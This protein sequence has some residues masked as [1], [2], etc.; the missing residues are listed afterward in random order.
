M[1]SDIVRP[2]D[3]LIKNHTKFHKIFT[4]SDDLVALDPKKY[5]KNNYSFCFPEKINIGLEGRDKLCT[6]IAGNKMIYKPTELY[7]KRLEAI[8]WFEKYHLDDFD[9]Y[10]IYWDE[11]WIRS[12]IKIFRAFNRLKLLRKWIRV[13]R[14]SYKGTVE[15]KKDILE[16]YRFSI[17]YENAS[18]NGYITEKIFDSFFAGCVP[19]YLGAP[20][21]LEY[22]PS[23]CFIDKRNFKTYEDLYDY[24]SNM[25]EKEYL[26]YQNSIVDFLNSEKGYEFSAE[27]NAEIWINEFKKDGII[28]E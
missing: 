26:S 11:F 8:K 13:N 2:E 23:E 5:I 6:M 15:K 12:K 24:I 20:N 14:P 7:S 17:C 18:S 10:G 1:E 28:N 9:L 4:W 25:S 19:I 3:F 21:I 22:I 27:R 16:G